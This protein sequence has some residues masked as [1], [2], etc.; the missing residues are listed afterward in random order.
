ML[1]NLE[2]G[3]P[4]RQIQKRWDLSLMVIPCSFSRRMGQQEREEM[5]KQ[6]VL[7][8]LL[9]VA[10]GANLV[11]GAWVVTTTLSPQTA[12]GGTVD[13]GA[14]ITVATGRIQG[15]GDADALYIWDH[16]DK[17]LAVYFQSGGKLELL[18]VRNCEYDMVPNQFG[19]Q[20]PTYQEMKKNVRKKN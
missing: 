2:F 1:Q 10:L 14:G 7:T 9:G 16:A 15:K 3:R 4:V 6:G 19:D 18:A 8:L 5:G 12:L 20:K 17:K 13:T 11:L